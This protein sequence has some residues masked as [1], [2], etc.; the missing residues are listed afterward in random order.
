M[1]IK[2]P[3]NYGIFLALSTA[4]MHFLLFPWFPMLVEK[5]YFSVIFVA[6]KWIL[7]P[8]GIFPIP[9]L[10]LLCMGVLLFLFIR[11]KKWFQ[12]TDSSGKFILRILN[13]MGLLLFLFYLNWGFNYRLPKMVD[14]LE[15]EVPNYSTDRLIHLYCSVTDELLQAREEWSK[16]SI[17]KNLAKSALLQDVSKQ[18][19]EWLRE[20]HLLVPV[21]ARI[22]ALPRGLLLRIGTAGFYNPLGGEGYWDAGLHAFVIPFV[23]A[24]ELAHNYGITDEGEANFVAFHTCIQSPYSFIRY[25]GYLNF[26][27]YVAGQLR[28][29]DPVQFEAEWASLSEDIKSDL[30]SIRQQHDQYPDIFPRLRDAI[31]DTFLRTQGVKAGMQSYGEVV[32]LELAYRDLKTKER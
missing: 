25:S 10:Y 14:R 8:F 20:Y 11:L 2:L 32:L 4:L 18:E 12:G 6:V 5:V 24:H 29:S 7:W 1:I 15:W 9:S 16:D 3:Q 27:R 22:R 13:G 19:K 17:Q 21:P 30:R 26:W 31:Y 23:M 28:R